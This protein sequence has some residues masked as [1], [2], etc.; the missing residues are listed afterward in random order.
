[1]VLQKLRYPDF[2][3]NSQKSCISLN[4]ALKCFNIHVFTKHIPG[5]NTGRLLYGVVSSLE[6]SSF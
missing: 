5:C 2:Q 3:F 4:A 1:M 6:L